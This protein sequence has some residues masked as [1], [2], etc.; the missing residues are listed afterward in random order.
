MKIVVTGGNGLVGN[1]L[2]SIVNE[3]YTNHSF[4]Y[5]NRSKNCEVSITCI[6]ENSNNLLFH[7]NLN[8]L[9][10]T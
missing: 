9:A 10:L 4:T 3:K 2:K 8:F 6:L 7:T 1:N 5:L